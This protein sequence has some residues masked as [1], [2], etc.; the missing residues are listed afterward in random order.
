[1]GLFKFV[2][3]YYRTIQICGESYY[4]LLFKSSSP[5]IGLFKFMES[6]Y[7]TIQICGVLLWD[8]SNLWSP[9]I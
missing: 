3:S 6:Y 1:M 5:I 7:R 2:E 9:I 4:R 8:Y